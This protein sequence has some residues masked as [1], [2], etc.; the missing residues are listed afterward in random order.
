VGNVRCDAYQALEF[1]QG[2]GVLFS[3]AEQ[4]GTGFKERALCVE[5]IEETEFSFGV[6][7]FSCSKRR[8]G[9]RHNL[10]LHDFGLQFR[11][12]QALEPRREVGFKVDTDSLCIS[13]DPLE[14]EVRC[15]SGTLISIKNRNQK[16]DS[17]DLC[18]M[19]GS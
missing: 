4:K 5:H 9:S 18:H 6:A 14:L 12:L 13:S 2:Q 11:C 10:G 15:L 1:G 19:S 17:S 3:T 8:F 16:G 7:R